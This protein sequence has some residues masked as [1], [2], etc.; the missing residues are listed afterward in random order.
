MVT[1]S[2]YIE[3]ISTEPNLSLTAKGLVLYALN[4]GPNGFVRADA[5]RDNNTNWHVITK[6]IQ[7]LEKHGYLKRTNDRRPGFTFFNNDI[8]ELLTGRLSQLHNRK[9]GAGQNKKRDLEGFVRTH[10]GGEEQREAR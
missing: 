2:K 8:S 4:C 1:R 7:E 6:A 10:P 9:A 3:L 5:V